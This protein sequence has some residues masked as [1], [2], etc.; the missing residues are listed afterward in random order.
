MLQSVLV[1]MGRGWSSVLQS[2][3][4]AMGCGWSSVL[5]AVSDGYYG[6]WLVHAA[7]SMVAKGSGICAA[8]SY[9]VGLLW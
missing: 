7:V 4:V 5:H 9:I 3:M 1:T 6:V 8:V 2:V